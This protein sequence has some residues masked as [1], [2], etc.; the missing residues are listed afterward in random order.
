MLWLNCTWNFIRDLLDSWSRC[1]WNYTSGQ[2]NQC[3]AAGHTNNT[4]S[5]GIYAVWKDKDAEN[6]IW[7]VQR[8]TLFTRIVRVPASTGIPEKMRKVFQSGKVIE[9]LNFSW[10]SGNFGRVGKKSGKFYQKIRKNINCRVNTN[11]DISLLKIGSRWRQ[12]VSHQWILGTKVI[13]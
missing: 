9:F 3:A 6:F 11:T 13:F 12:N 5:Q 2:W 10:K 4:V 1:G 7:R 8:F